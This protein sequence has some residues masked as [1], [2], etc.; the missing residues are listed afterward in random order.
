M[1]LLLTPCWRLPISWGWLLNIMVLI[2]PMARCY[3]S[4]LRAVDGIDRGGSLCFM[5]MAALCGDVMEQ[6]CVAIAVCVSAVS[7]GIGC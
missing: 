7:G 2:V 3:G 5:I 1:H 6:K 4:S